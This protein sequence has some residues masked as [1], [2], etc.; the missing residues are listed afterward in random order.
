[1]I[2]SIIISNYFY[3]IFLYFRSSSDKYKTLLVVIEKLYL[4]MVE[5]GFSPTPG[6]YI[7]LILIIHFV[8]LLF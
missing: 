5:L 3:F 1:M 8:L 6:K 7:Y 4:A 2:Q